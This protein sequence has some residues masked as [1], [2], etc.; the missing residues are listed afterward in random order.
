[1]SDYLVRWSINLY[2]NSPREAAQ[3]AL[4][5]Q[6]DATSIAHVYE[7]IKIGEGLARDEHTLI[8]LDFPE[9]GVV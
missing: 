4:E 8:D 1:M 3:M 7:V 2:A 6:K 9:S 5:I